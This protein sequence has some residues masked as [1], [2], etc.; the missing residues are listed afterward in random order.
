MVRDVVEDIVRVDD[1]A[2]VRALRLLVERMKLVVEPSGATGLAAEQRG[3]VF[4]VPRKQRG[5]GNAERFEC[6]ANARLAAQRNV[7]AFLRVAVDA[8]ET[9]KHAAICCSDIDNPGLAPRNVAFNAS[10]LTVAL[11]GDPFE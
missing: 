4:F 9:F 11:P 3:V 7:R 2:I 6:G 10:D 5:H 8:Q 1:P